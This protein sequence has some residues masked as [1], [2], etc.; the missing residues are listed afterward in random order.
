VKQGPWAITKACSYLGR[1]DSME[2]NTN[3]RCHILDSAASELFLPTQQTVCTTS[4]SVPSDTFRR[5]AVSVTKTLAS[6]R[7]RCVCVWLSGYSF[8]KLPQTKKNKK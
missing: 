7:D 8:R 2:T 3:N 1:Y 5:L 6:L 4:C